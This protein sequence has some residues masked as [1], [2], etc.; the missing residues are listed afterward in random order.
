MKISKIIMLMA[1]ILIAFSYVGMQQID[2]SMIYQF[3]LVNLI[4]GVILFGAAVIE[5]FHQKK[6]AKNAPAPVKEQVILPKDE[7]IE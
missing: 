1:V 7:T 4:S 5:Y 3:F 2:D 6:K